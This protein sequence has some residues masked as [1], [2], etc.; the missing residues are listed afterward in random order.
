MDY[1]AAA[2]GAYSAV[3]GADAGADAAG[4]QIVKGGEGAGRDAGVSGGG[5]S[6]AYTESDPGRVQGTGRHLH[7][8]LAAYALEVSEPDGVEA[9]GLDILDALDDP[10]H[11][12]VAEDAD[13]EFHEL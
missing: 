3:T 12:L 10:G 2:Y 11:G 5:H 13:G 7:V 6:D 9:E 4:G 1:G 8:H